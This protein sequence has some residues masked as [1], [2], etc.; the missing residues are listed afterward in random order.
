MQ[1]DLS[2]SGSSPQEIFRVKAVTPIARSPIFEMFYSLIVSGQSTF[3]ANVIYLGFL[4][5]LAD[6]AGSAVCY[7]LC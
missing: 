7:C 3:R 4:R 1:K 6:G 5:F 2:K